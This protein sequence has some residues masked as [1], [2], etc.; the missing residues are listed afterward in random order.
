MYLK[1][2]ETVYILRPELAEEN[3]LRVI[4]RYQGILIERGAKNIRI[5]NRGKRRLKYPL[6][7]CRDGVYVQMN[8]EANGEVVA[9]LNSSLRIDD[10]ILRSLTVKCN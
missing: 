6:K 9:L 3:L 5:E 10:L 8:Y 4:D 2:Y 1:I 7:K